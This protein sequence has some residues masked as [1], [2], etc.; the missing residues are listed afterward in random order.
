MSKCRFRNS[1]GVFY[2]FLNKP[3]YISSLKPFFAYDWQ[4]VEVSN[5]I[6]GYNRKGIFQ[7]QIELN[8]LSDNR[9]NAA[10]Q[11]EII[12]AEFENDVIAGK[13]SRIYVNDYYLECNITARELINR[14]GRTQTYLLTVTTDRM[15]WVK[16]LQT[17]TFTQNSVI[18][19]SDEYEDTEIPFGVP[20]GF[21]NPNESKEFTNSA[22]TPCNFRLKIFG[23]CSDPA[24]S[25]AGHTYSASIALEPEEALVI[26]SAAA[27]LTK[28]SGASSINCFSARSSESNIFEKIPPGVCSVEWSDISKFQLTLI[29]ERSAPKCV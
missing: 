23:S 9:S 12:F 3:Y 26:D 17:I 11:A 6:S 2:D 8:I 16:E 24:I 22:L 20:F 15:K 28:L 7:K 13:Y 18:L 27:T 1:S 25:I 10:E 14:V 21:P 5:A 29:E 19:E 4:P